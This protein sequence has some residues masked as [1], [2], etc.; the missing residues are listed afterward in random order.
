MNKRRLL[1][2]ADLLEADAKNKKG[3]QFDLN[4]IACKAAG[5]NFESGDEPAINCGTAACAIGLACL[6]GAFRRAGLEYTINNWGFTP[7]VDG[8]ADFG[9]AYGVFGLSEEEGDFLFLPDSYPRDMIGA[10]GERGVAKRIRD[11]VA[12]KASPSND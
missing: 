11:F 7:L 3:I 5:A 2:L 12:G 10:R 1:K 6:S 8:V 9:A 4:V